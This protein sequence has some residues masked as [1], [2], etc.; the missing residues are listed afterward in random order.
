MAGVVE[1]LRKHGAMDYTIVVVAGASDPAPL[2]YVAPYAG[3]AMAEY[4]MY[5]RAATLCRLRRLSK[6]AVAYRQC[7]C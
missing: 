3:T 4:F 7:R 2:Q 5:S 1:A 6:Q